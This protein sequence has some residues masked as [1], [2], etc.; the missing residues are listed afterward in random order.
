MRIQNRQ[1]L[2]IL[3]AILI[4]FASIASC[5]L[6]VTVSAC[7]ALPTDT[8]VAKKSFAIVS[9][10]TYRLWAHVHTSSSGD[11][12]L[13]M[14]IDNGCPISVG[15]SKL[16]AGAFSWV[17]HIGN[18]TTP[19][20]IELTSGAHTLAVAGKDANVG[21]DRVILLAD[22]SC[23]PTGNGSNC[24]VSATSTPPASSSVTPATQPSKNSS[25]PIQ[26][27]LSTAKKVIYVAASALIAALF[28]TILLRYVAKPNRLLKRLPFFKDP[29]PQTLPVQ[30]LPPSTPVPLDTTP[31]AVTA[32][33]VITDSPTFGQEPKR[34]RTVLLVALGFATVGGLISFIVLAAPS[35]VVIDL[36]SATVSG[37]AHLVADANAVSGR[38]IQFGSG[39]AAHQP[40]PKTVPSP[41]SKS[42]SNTP[43][44]SPSGSTAVT[45][46]A[47]TNPTWNSSDPQA[48]DPIGNDG[49]WWID[50]D[51]WSG[52]HGP[53]TLYVCSPSSWYAISNQTNN[54]GQV[55]TYPD[56]EYDVGGRSTPSTKTIAQYTSITS[57]FSES[58]PAAGSWDAAY[59]LWLNNWN[60][61]IMIW[62]Q[63]TGTQLYWPS[64]KSVTVNLG[65]V[66]YWF[67][68]NGGEFIFFRQNMVTS[69]SVD[70]LAAFK[71]LVSKGLVKSTDIPTQLEYGVEVCATN[72][73]EKFP[74]NGL[75]FTLN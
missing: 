16:T 50:N 58:F 38:M 72:G 42:P 25:T 63:W 19:I 18:S 44:E 52:S 62:N 1:S 65:G 4:L 36:T 11:S 8:G 73:N 68:N 43:K 20:S 41:V 10:G 64:D 60:T 61:E 26:H 33:T 12:A 54:G 32:G 13:A 22:S 67:Q 21:I 23:V 56:S 70:I 37:Q 74:M 24:V 7:A 51:A 31:G 53:Q 35:S 17:D 69:G 75:T 27:Q 5:A 15:G 39:K 34:K 3:C 28:G 40:I 55:E 14:A 29:I 57:T 45:S 49:I 71:Y 9:A 47:C 59:D 66:P 2:A 46:S 6:P 30:S 48:T